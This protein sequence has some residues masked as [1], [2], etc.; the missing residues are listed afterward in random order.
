MEEVTMPST[1]AAFSLMVRGSAIQ[2]AKER[3]AAA[4]VQAALI[5]IDL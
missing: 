1:D 2:V 3:F 4:C 5:Y